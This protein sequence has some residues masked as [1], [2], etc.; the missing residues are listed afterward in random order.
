MTVLNRTTACR[1]RMPRE[2]SFVVEGAF[3][4]RSGGGAVG[5]IAAVFTVCVPPVRVFLGG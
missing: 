4:L 1:F 5:V 3:V 2:I